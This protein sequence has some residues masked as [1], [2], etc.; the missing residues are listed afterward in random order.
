MELHTRRLS[1]RHFTLDDADFVVELVNDPDWIR[2]IGDR[3]VRTVE[4]ARA[5][6]ERGPLALYERH[7]FGLYLVSLLATG[8]RIGM[9]GLVKRDGLEHVD[10][11]FAF[12]PAW[13]G[14]GFA[15]E[16]ARAVLAHARELGVGKVVAIVSPDNRPS[17]RLLEKIGMRAAGPLRLPKAEDDV[18]LYEA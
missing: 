15:E 4:D 8:E 2:N 13:R 5:Y 1:L 18:M 14:R 10:I 6:L 11:G 16:S 12:L 9:C 7:G 3:N 17:I